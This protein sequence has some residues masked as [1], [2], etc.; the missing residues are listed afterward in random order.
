MGS[1]HVEHF[2][3]LCGEHLSVDNMNHAIERVAE[4]FNIAIKEFTVAGIPEGSLFS[5]HWYVG[6]DD[7]VD[8]ELLRK[9]VAP[10]PPSVRCL[11]QECARGI[12]LVSAG[13]MTG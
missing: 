11:L 5:H 9:R 1:I 12:L 8:K 6:T 2:L 7:P 13:E 4:E 3:S 10:R